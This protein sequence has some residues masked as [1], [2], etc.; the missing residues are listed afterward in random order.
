MQKRNRNMFREVSILALALALN[1]NAMKNDGPLIMYTEYQTTST[2]FVDRIVHRKMVA[3]TNER[4]KQ[5]SNKR[6]FCV[7]AILL[8]FSPLYSLLSQIAIR[9]Y[10]VRAWQ[11]MLGDGDGV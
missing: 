1:S 3:H 5:N 8:L 9:F 7:F 11:A 10:L 4:S 2:R 6:D